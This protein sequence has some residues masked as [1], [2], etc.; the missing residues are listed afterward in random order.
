MKKIALIAI[1]AVIGTAV[2]F[3]GGSKDGASKQKGKTVIRVLANVDN[4]TQDGADW[5]D[6]V[7]KFEADNPDVDVQDVTVYSEAYHQK[8]RAMLAAKDYPHVAYIWPDARGVYFKEAGQLVDNKPYMDPSYYDFSQIP[9]MGPNG[10]IW[11]VPDGA[12]NFCSVL[13]MNAEILKKYGFAEPK[14]YA[15]LV[16]MVAPLKKDGISVIS[17]S[18]ADSWVWGSCFMSGIVPRYTG[19]ADWVSKAVKGE[20]SF[21]DPAFVKALS[22]IT[23]MTVDGV[24]PAAT[25]VTDYGTALTNFI[26]GKAAFMIDGQW[27]A[28]GVEDLELQKAVKMITFPAFPGEKPA[29]ANSVAAALSVGFGITK[30]ATEDKALLDASVRFIRAVNSPENVTRR[31]LNGSVVAPVEFVD[32]PSGMTPIVLEKMRYSKSVGPLTDVID[33]YLPPAANDA[34][35]VGM[36]NIALGKTTPEEVAAEVER[37]VRAAE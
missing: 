33:S 29:M 20:R 16:A 5:L 34:L 18:G 17:M 31:W 15:D 3:A 25:M 36:Q 21:T 19:E 6:I 14:T 32:P 7:A 4:S 30:A 26:T 8:A 37:L 9:A 1:L 24:L 11:E 13:Y 22:V 12:S 28:N 27:R 23:T 35:N 2:C 10:E